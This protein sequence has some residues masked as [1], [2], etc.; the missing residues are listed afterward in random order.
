MRCYRDG[1]GALLHEMRINMGSGMVNDKGNGENNALCMLP[2]RILREYD[3]Q[4]L[5]PGKSRSN[6][7]SLT[8]F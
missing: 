3:I 4:V 6:N 1:L 5:R 8:D 2:T 7:S